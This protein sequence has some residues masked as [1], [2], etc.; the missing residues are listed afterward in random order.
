MKTASIA[1]FIAA[2]L[3]SLTVH[4]QSTG[5]TSL[6]NLRDHQRV[7][8]VFA[9]TPD[10]PQ[11]QIQLRTLNEHAADAST[12]DLVPIAL[13]YNAPSPTPATL[14]TADA[15]A[16]RRRYHVAPTEFT[17]ILI[18]KDGGEKLRAHKPFS[19]SEL[20][21]TIDSMPMRQDEMKQQR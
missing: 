2:A 4:A 3:S 9:P 14:T 6:H 21:A 18:G 17:A 8:L 11:L 10:D 1:T 7:L 16:V 5:I 19:M 15:D 13:P 20:N 12:R